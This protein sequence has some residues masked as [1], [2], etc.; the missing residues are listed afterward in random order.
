[1]DSFLKYTN[2]IITF[3]K[4]PKICTGSCDNTNITLE[5]QATSMWQPATNVIDQAR[6]FSTYDPDTDLNLVKS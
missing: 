5:Y 6:F 3:T 4:F 1:M 2:I